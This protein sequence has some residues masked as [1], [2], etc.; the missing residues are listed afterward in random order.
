MSLFQ[1]LLAPLL[2]QSVAAIRTFDC[3]AGE[4]FSSAQAAYN[5]YPDV[6]FCVD[7]YES[8]R[9]IFWRSD[10]RFQT[11]LAF[12]PLAIMVLVILIFPII[13]CLRCC[14]NIPCAS[15]RGASDAHTRS[16]SNEPF[17]GEKAENQKVSQSKKARDGNDRP[18]CCTWRYLPWGFQN[19]E[20]KKAAIC[21]LITGMLVAVVWVIC[22]V[23]QGSVRLPMSFERVARQSIDEV[24][25]SVSII[26][27]QLVLNASSNPPTYIEP[28]TQADIDEYYNDVRDPAIREI[29]YYAD[30]I[31]PYVTKVV[32]GLAFAAAVPLLLIGLA[33]FV[34]FCRS[35]CHRNTPCAYT[36]TLHATSCCSFLFIIFFAIVT[37]AFWF[38]GSVVHDVCGERELFLQN[39]DAPGLINYMVLPACEENGNSSFQDANDRVVDGERQLAEVVCETLLT[40][41]DASD[42]YND[43]PYKCANLTSKTQ[44]GDYYTAKGTAAT[45]QMKTSAPVRCGV[46]TGTTD[47]DVNNYDIPEDYQQYIDK[48]VGNNGII[49]VPNTDASTQF[50]CPVETC[51]NQCNDTEAAAGSQLTL[52][53]LNEADL[54]HQTIADHV[55]PYLSCRKVINKLLNRW[56]TCD[57]TVALLWI[58]GVCAF[59]FMLLLILLVVLIW[60]ML[61]NLDDSLCSVLAFSCRRKE[62]PLVATAVGDG[63]AERYVTP[64]RSPS[65]QYPPEE[66]APSF[67]EPE[68]VLNPVFVIPR[69]ADIIET[70][71]HHIFTSDAQKK[72]AH[73]PMVRTLGE[74]IYDA[75]GT[76]GVITTVV[77]KRGDRVIET[78]DN[79]G[80]RASAY[81]P[82]QSP[83]PPTRHNTPRRG[84]DEPY[85]NDN[86]VLKSTTMDF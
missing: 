49:Q 38:A 22:L 71:E 56:T 55:N 76:D 70:E 27:Q 50:L 9:N 53:I 77:R 80:S 42:E 28:L 23:V 61:R 65:L 69:A 29:N 13:W 78:Y 32:V 74:R 81:S 11:V 19:N 17:D 8:V 39:P 37:A 68:E 10:H 52:R 4:N 18:D 7:D 3:Y 54:V 41:C 2:A 33:A 57:D 12:F 83:Q 51:A 79:R 60:L 25:N 20:G 72:L 45:L 26:T 6:T 30:M 35:K 5:K 75:E 24:T 43:R 64:I 36:T 58:I 21:L 47:Y 59:L 85:N 1:I 66:E 40:L 15:G 82:R 86:D 34:G 14:C 46:V 48:L 73:N 67:T 31:R 84:I 62:K 63:Q 16:G 44:C